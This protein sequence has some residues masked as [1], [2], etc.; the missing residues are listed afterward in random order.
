MKNGKNLGA[1]L[2]AVFAGALVCVAV[3]LLNTLSTGCDRSFYQAQQQKLGIAESLGM[4]QQQVDALTRETIDFLRG[5]RADYDLRLEDGTAIFSENE[6]THMKDVQK[7][8]TLAKKVSVLCIGV[9]AALGA[10]L[11]LRRRR[12]GILMYCRG[13]RIGCAVFAGLLAG[14]AV[15]AA[16]NWNAAFAAFHA[17]FRFGDSWLFP[18][19][20]PLIELLPEP[21]FVAAGVRVAVLTAVGWAALCAASLFVTKY[22]SRPKKPEQKQIVQEEIQH[23]SADRS[24]V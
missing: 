8:F 20:S 9:S 15:F 17:V 18:E 11:Y 19:G 10:F 23:D 13:L 3:L 22:P 6:Q 2:T 21:L 24:H 1:K 14:V 12:E 4:T 5:R 7:L 16:V